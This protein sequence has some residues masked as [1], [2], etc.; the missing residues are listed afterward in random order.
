MWDILIP[1]RAVKNLIMTMIFVGGKLKNKLRYYHLILEDIKCG[2]KLIAVCVM[3]LD[4]NLLRLQ[5]L[6]EPSV[7]ADNLLDIIPVYFP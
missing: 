6:S 1:K 2:K 4:G 5:P 7:S 3:I